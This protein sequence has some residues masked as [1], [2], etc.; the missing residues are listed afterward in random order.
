MY[1]FNPNNYGEE[2]FVMAEDKIMAHKYLLKHLENKIISESSCAKMLQ[3]DLDI[4]KKVNPLNS[5]T[6]PKGY[7]LDEHEVGSVIQS[8]IA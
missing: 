5:T 1:H 7:S 3:E 8:E 6:F 4:W 2:F